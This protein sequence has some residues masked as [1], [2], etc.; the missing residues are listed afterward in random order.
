LDELR[1][2]VEREERLERLALALADG[3]EVDEFPVVLRRKSDALL[4]CDAPERGGVDRSAEMDVELGQLVAERVWD[5][6]PLLACGRAAHPAATARRRRTSLGVLG[7]DAVAVVVGGRDAH[8]AVPD[9]S[10]T[11]GRVRALAA[12]LAVEL[13]PHGAE[14]V[15]EDVRGSRH[16]WKFTTWA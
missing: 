14:D 11:P 6:A 3:D 7:P 15:N 5:L 2:V 12:I 13:I 8:E 4:V 1:P 16:L 10:A 9:L